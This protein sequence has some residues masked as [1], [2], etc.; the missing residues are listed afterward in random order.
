MVD[1]VLNI[2]IITQSIYMIWVR[3]TNYYIKSILL[4]LDPFR[5]HGWS[6]GIARGAIALL[7]VASNRY[8][9]TFW[10]FNR[11]FHALAGFIIATTT[12]SMSLYAFVTVE[13][14]LIINWHFYFIAPTCVLV[15]LLGVGEIM[16][17]RT[18]QTS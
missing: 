17:R 15:L 7:M 9:K 4:M 11:K 12:V 6:L 18:L 2:I 5:I 1:L 13:W 14:Y 8:L 10:N 3:M 16:T